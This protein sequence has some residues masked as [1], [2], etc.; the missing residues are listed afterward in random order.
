MFNWA[1]D[2]IIRERVFVAGRQAGRLRTASR[3]RCPA[4]PATTARST[5]RRTRADARGWRAAASGARARPPTSHSESLRRCSDFCSCASLGRSRCCF[6]LSV[7]TF[8]IIQAPPG[9]Y[10]DYIRSQ[11][12]NQGGASLRRRPT[13]QAE[14]Y[15]EAQRP[16][17][18]RCR[19][20]FPLDHRHRHPRRFRPQPLLQ[21]AG[22]RRR[23]RAPA[24]HARFWR[25][26]AI[27]W[28]RSSASPSASS[29]R[30]ANIP[31]SIPRCR[32]HLVPRHDGAA[33][34]DGADHRLHPGLPVQRSGD[35]QLLLR[36]NMAARPGP[37]TSSSTSCSTSGR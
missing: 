21:Q 16:R 10:G 35:R 32:L 25:W 8:A 37:G 28:R 29:P 19:P 27:S 11:L 4:S 9:D 34:P 1:E 23:R 36:R 30:P 26:S 17:T 15:R 14:A 6:V 12:I 7:V 18:I 22:R 24:A 31:G 2:N 13:P 5:D 20:V 3:A 33:L